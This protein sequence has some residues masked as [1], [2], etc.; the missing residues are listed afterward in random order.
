MT[1]WEDQFKSVINGRPRSTCKAKRFPIFKPGL[2]LTA[3]TT[4]LPIF[5]L[6]SK[7]E[8]VTTRLTPFKITSIPKKI[9]VDER[10]HL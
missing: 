6:R 8:K 2:L 1:Q 9:E 7:V 10:E 3:L 4:T 5:T